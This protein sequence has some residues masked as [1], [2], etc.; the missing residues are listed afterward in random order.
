MEQEEINK[1]QKDWIELGKQL[2][3]QIKFYRETDILT[4]ALKSL[5]MKAILWQSQL[6]RYQKVTDNVRIL[7]EAKAYIDCCK[8]C[9]HYTN[10]NGEGHAVSYV[11]Q[12]IRCAFA[13]E[14]KK[15]YSGPI[16]IVG[17]NE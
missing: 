17:N 1:Q 3:E 7:C 9:I 15:N 2:E 5:L 4:P 6:E 16:T 12:I 11:V 14:I 13:S 8:N 10:P